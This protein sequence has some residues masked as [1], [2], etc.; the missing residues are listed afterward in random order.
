MTALLLD[1]AVHSLL[2]SLAVAVMAR[3]AWRSRP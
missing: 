1:L 3:G 2:V